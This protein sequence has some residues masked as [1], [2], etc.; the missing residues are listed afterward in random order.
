MKFKGKKKKCSPTQQVAFR[1]IRCKRGFI[2]AI[3]QSLKSIEEGGSQEN[4]TRMKSSHKQA[5]TQRGETA[6]GL[7]TPYSVQRSRIYVHFS[8]Y[9]FSV[10]FTSHT[11]PETLV[12]SSV[13]DENAHMQAPVFSVEEFRRHTEDILPASFC[14]HSHWP[15]FPHP[16]HSGP[17]KS[18]HWIRA[19]LSLSLTP[20][21]SSRPYGQCLYEKQGMFC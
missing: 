2:H 13:Q 12:Q 19:L 5:V 17:A 21:E 7:T 10:S 1:W 18:C 8:T 6:R 9:S 16:I 15:Y 3:R 14:T 11:Y 20:P 4:H